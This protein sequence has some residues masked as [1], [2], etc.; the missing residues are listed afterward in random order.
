MRSLAGK[1]NWAV[2]GSR[3]DLVFP[4]VHISMKF[5][6]A[7]IVDL[8][9]VIKVIRHLKDGRSQVFFPNLGASNNW[10][11]LVFTDAAHA[12]LDDGVSSM[13]AY[14]VFLVGQNRM[15]CPLSW[16][17][18]KI[19]RVVRSTIAAEALSLQEGLE[20]AVYLKGMLTELTSASDIP[21]IAFVDNKSVVEAIHS[22]KLVEDKRL[23]IDIGAMKQS[24]EN[25]EVSAIKW[26][27]GNQQLANCMTKKGA[28]GC[29]LLTILQGGKFLLDV[30]F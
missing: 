19:K 6:K 16:N 1:L 28:S 30:N 21:I 26:C 17:G 22:T 29:D 24:L 20:D 8:L 12:N 5:K 10:N 11:I 7:K 3:P 9:M 14:I 23:R 18:N 2:Q 13:R 25:G 4:L 15:C 27:P